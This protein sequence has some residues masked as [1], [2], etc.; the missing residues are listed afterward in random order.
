[1]KSSGPD[2]INILQGLAAIG[3]LGAK[4]EAVSPD[5]LLRA[6]LPIKAH[7][8][9]LD[10]DI[11]LILGGRG[12]G[13]SHLF[14][15]INLPRGPEALGYEGKG[16][17]A[18]WLRGFAADSSGAHF[19][20]ETVL[21]R[22]A[23]H[24][25]RTDLVDFWRGLLAGVILALPDQA[26]RLLRDALPSTVTSA[27]ADLE[28]VSAWHRRVVES[29]EQVDAALRRLDDELERQKR[30]LFATYDDLDVMAVD[31]NEKRALIQALLQFWLGQWRRWRRI[32]PENIPPARPV[33]G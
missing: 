33:F 22:F 31:W 14:R 13:K 27:L 26:G 19:P 15:V 16:S 28:R 1:M 3:R 18:I 12:A 4:A 8:H 30:Y 29:V 25:N 2:H 23:E 17:D 20:G 6:T 7:L 11:L 9:A 10:P 24:K 5:D 32:R 21:G